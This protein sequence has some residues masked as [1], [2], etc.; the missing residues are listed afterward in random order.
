MKII[1][2]QIGG[3]IFNLN[4]VSGF[5]KKSNYLVNKINIF[6]YKRGYR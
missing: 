4:L 3:D 6:L 1:K 5:A 2:F